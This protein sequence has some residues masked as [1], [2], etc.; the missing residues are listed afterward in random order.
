[1]LI[2]GRVAQFLIHVEAAVK[3]HAFR[4]LAPATK[5]RRIGVSLV[6][7]LQGFLVAKT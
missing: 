5:K 2:F 7:A 1:V 6:N 4:L 3:R